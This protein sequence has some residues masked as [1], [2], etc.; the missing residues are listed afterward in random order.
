MGHGA[1]APLLWLS[2]RPMPRAPTDAQRGDE[3]ATRR[4]AIMMMR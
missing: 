4:A 2:R 3:S 1:A